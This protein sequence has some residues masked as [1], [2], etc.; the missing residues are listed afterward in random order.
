MPGRARAQSRAYST[1]CCSAVYPNSSGKASSAAVCESHDGQG[2][3]RRS[4]YQERGVWRW[5][6][7]Y[8]APCELFG[9]AKAKLGDE[10]A[11]SPRQTAPKLT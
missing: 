5:L 7:M 6:Q 11:S 1:P 8:P 3:R 2:K 9:L 4:V 10:C